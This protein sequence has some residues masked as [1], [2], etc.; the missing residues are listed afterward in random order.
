VHLSDGSD[1][2]VRRW[3][4]NV[5]VGGS[6]FYVGAE[7]RPDQEHAIGRVDF[8]PARVI[9]PDGWRMAAVGEAL[10]TVELAAAALRSLTCPVWV[11]IDEW[12]V[13]RLDVGKD[14]GGV[15][16]PGVMLAAVGRVPA[17]WSKLNMTHAGRNGAQTV[18]RGSKSAGM[19]RAYDKCAET[20]G[21]APEGTVRFETEGRKGWLRNYGEIAMLRDVTVESVELF[22]RNR[23]EWSGVGVEVA[24]SLGQLWSKVQSIEASDRERMFFLSYLVVSAAGERPPVSKMS[25]AKYGRWQREAGI[26]APF[27]VVGE[28]V[29]VVR[30]LDWESAREVVSVRAA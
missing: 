4:A 9:E 29:E 11:D 18:T 24:G 17:R 21:D 20:K 3:G 10:G 5:E 13:S 7:K 28:A 19:V 27:D 6:R 22:A 26:A 8:N 30:R 16:D 15:E 25:A 23:F 2:V 12:A 14:F 1:G